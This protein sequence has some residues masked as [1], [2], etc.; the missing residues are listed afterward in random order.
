MI[1]LHH[2]TFDNKPMGGYCVEFVNFFESDT[3]YY[4]VLEYVGK[5]NLS[6]FT[7]KAHQYIKEGKLS[8]KDWKKIVRFLFWQIA[9]TINW[10]H[11]DLGICHLDLKLENIMVKNGNFIETKI[12]NSTRISIDCNVSIKICDFGVAEIFK[13]KSNDC[14]EINTDDEYFDEHETFKC[15]KNHYSDQY[16]SLQVFDPSLSANVYDARKADI[17]LGIILFRMCSNTVPYKSADLVIRL[18]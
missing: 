15:C 3:D 9:V 12:G 6:Q 13:Q 8:S 17:E 11:Q 16:K 14:F 10:F 18:V 4:L 7:T 5:Y 2:I 1:L